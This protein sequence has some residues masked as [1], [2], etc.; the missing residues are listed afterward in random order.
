M[1]TLSC[2]LMLT[3]RGADTS[4][5]WAP[6]PP[7]VPNPRTLIHRYRVAYFSASGAAHARLMLTWRGADTSSLHP[8]PYTLHPTHYTLHPTPDTPHPTPYTLHPLGP[9]A[10]PNPNPRTLAHRYRVT[11]FSASGAAH[12]RLMLTW[13][14]AD[15]SSLW[16]PLPSRT[17]TPEPAHTGTV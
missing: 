1:L 15:T 4:S 9:A 11:Y 17:L 6:L 16:A 5:A 3:W 10:I 2:C 14:G 8:T 7:W 13:R 12:A